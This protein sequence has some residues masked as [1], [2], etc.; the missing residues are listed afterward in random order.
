[1]CFYLHVMNTFAF[2]GRYVVIS[3][4]HVVNKNH[5]VIRNQIV[6]FAKKRFKLTWLS[7]VVLVG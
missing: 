4:A 2:T 5:P 3:K 6:W 1:M 7:V